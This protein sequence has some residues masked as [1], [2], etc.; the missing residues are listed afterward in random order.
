MSTLRRRHA[1]HLRGG[2]RGHAG[3]RLVWMANAGVILAA[4][5][6]LLVVRRIAFS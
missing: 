1:P 5:G 3:Y 6:V 4:A 2:N